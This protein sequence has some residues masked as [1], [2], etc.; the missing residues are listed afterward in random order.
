[1][2]EQIINMMLELDDEHWG[3]FISALA[4]AC[5][6]SQEDQSSSAS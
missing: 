1:M 2:T 3:I 6:A 5:E 4:A